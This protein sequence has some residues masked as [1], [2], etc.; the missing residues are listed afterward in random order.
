MMLALS[1][2]PVLA[3]ENF[4]WISDA[5]ISDRC[6]NCF[7]IELGNCEISSAVLVNGSRPV[8]CSRD[9]PCIGCET[10]Y[11]ALGW[12]LQPSLNCEK[13]WAEEEKE[14]VSLDL[15]KPRTNTIR[16]DETAAET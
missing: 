10:C 8:A 7:Q 9:A 3:G 5:I 16:V 12:G 14:E 13:T 15:G 4:D 2:E 6:F 1:P 11:A